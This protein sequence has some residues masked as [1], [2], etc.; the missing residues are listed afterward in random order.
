MYNLPQN[1]D[2]DDDERMGLT[3][4]D[5]DDNANTNY[6]DGE[7]GK[8][9][10]YDIKMH[11]SLKPWADVP[12]PPIYPGLIPAVFSLLAWYY[13]RGDEGD[14]DGHDGDADDHA[15]DH[16][17]GGSDNLRLI[18]TPI[19]LRWLLSRIS[20]L[21]TNSWQIWPWQRWSCQRWSWQRWRWS[22]L[23]SP[24][25]ASR[26]PRSSSTSSFSCVLSWRLCSRLT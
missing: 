13:H 7:H 2:A 11:L 18:S 10:R 14:A 17:N 3:T 1:N 21:F 12:A 15:D 9:K 22:T 25:R 24:S 20:C 16:D 6:I 19:C 26:R 23:I 4:N 5:G 8:G